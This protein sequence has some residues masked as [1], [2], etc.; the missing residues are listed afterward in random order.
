[1]RQ[2]QHMGL[3]PDAQHF[4]EENVVTIPDIICPNCG[5]VI[6]Q[7]MDA[8]VIGREALFYDDGPAII[9]YKLDDGRICTEVLQCSPWS[10]GPMGF[11]CLEIDG[12][13]MFEWTDEEIEVYGG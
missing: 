6:K 1:M 5:E 7:K 11:M 12:K 9:E 8:T 3:T 13:R 2:Y 4:L 10:S